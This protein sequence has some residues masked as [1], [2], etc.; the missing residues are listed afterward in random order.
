MQI[1]FDINTGQPGGFFGIAVPGSLRRPLA[2]HAGLG[3]LNLGYAM[4]NARSVGEM[5]VPGTFV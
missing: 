4:S 1:I 3:L 5:K 2:M